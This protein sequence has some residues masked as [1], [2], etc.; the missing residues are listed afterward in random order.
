MN[1]LGLIA[2]VLSLHL[3]QM[4]ISL[5]R[6]GKPSSFHS[7]SAKLAA[8]GIGVF[9]LATFDFDFYPWLFFLACFLLVLDAVEESILVLLLPNWKNDVK[10]IYWV[11]R[12]KRVAKTATT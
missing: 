9:V 11:V 12:K 1:H 3:I 4:L 7:Y 5:Y 8:F 2:I 6:Y 10:G